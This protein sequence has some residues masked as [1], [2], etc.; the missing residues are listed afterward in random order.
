LYLDTEKHQ[1]QYNRGEKGE[2]FGVQVNN[3]P[4]ECRATRNER[5]WSLAA[6]NLALAAVVL[7]FLRRTSTGVAN[8][9]PQPPA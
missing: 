8:P 5:P 9:G 2:L 3:P 1:L 4:E 6:G 7:V